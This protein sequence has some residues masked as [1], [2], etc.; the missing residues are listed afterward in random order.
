MTMPNFLIIGSAKSGSTALYRYLKQHPQIFMSAVKEPSFFA[1]E[2]E[3]LDFRAPSGKP[4]YIN[5]YG[6]NHIKEYRR[7]FRKVE[8][9]K[10]VGEASIMYLSDAKAPERIRHHI[11]HAKL[12]AILR[13]PVDI[14]YTCFIMDLHIGLEPFSE[15]RDALRDEERR[16]QS[17]CFGGKYVQI[18]FHHRH[19]TRYLS[20]FSRDQMRIYLYDEFVASSETVVKDVFRFLDVDSTFV[21]DMSIRENVS[22]F[23]RNK[24]LHLLL[25]R[26][27]N[28]LI[29]YISPFMPHGMRRLFMNVRNRNLA[30]PRL[31]PQLRKELIEVF[32]PDILRL[33]ELTDR[34][35]SKWL[36]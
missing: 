14:A 15:F 27:G 30:K 13:N 28:P 21:P 5:K 36:E 11:P 3:K 26:R 18:G 20:L 33:Q 23:P 2:G 31:S 6:V 10:A 34:D 1:L 8:D 12:I 22:G 16:I 9:E 32:R 29:P 24:A 35:L 17:K 7:L 25:S 4:P 19:L